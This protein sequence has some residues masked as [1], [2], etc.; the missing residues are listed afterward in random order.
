MRANRTA[1]HG[2][3]PGGEGYTGRTPGD[4]ASHFGY[5]GSNSEAVAWGDFGVEDMVQGL[6]D[7]PYHRVLFM[8]PRTPDFG[9]SYLQGTLCI[10]FGGETGNGVV[11]S[12]ADGAQNVRPYW[13][14]IETPDPLRGTGLHGAVGYPIVLAAFGTSAEGFRFVSAKLSGPDG[15]VKARVLHPGN[16]EHADRAVIVIPHK[17]LAKDTR[18]TVVIA[19]ANSSGAREARSTFTTAR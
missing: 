5:R 11:V 14:G 2:L 18:Y 7:A 16:D 10:K 12:P 1:G 17:P 15:A 8:Q 19:Y 4:R 6:F 13:D 9:G 3:T